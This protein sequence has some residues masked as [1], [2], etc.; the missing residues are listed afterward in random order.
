MASV[1]S[2]RRLGSDFE[3]HSDGDGLRTADWDNFGR[4]NLLRK[5]IKMSIGLW[6][7]W[8]EIPITLWKQVLYAL[9]FSEEISINR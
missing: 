1:P 8:V 2:P 7:Q 4:G 6:L 9:S 3:A 5:F